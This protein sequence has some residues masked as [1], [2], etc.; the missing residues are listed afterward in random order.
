M[1]KDIHKASKGENRA[2][3]EQEEETQT[4]HHKTM[5]ITLLSVMQHAARNEGFIFR[6]EPKDV[7]KKVASGMIKPR[8]FS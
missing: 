3:S 8:F 2:G 6:N 1:D 5:S 7:N 4:R